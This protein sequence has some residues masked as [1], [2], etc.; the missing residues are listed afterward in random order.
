MERSGCDVRLFE[1]CRVLLDPTPNVGCTY[2]VKGRSWYGRLFA[3]VCLGC[4][5]SLFEV[6]EALSGFGFAQWCLLSGLG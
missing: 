6:Y 1:V 2:L 3:R 5:R 4:N